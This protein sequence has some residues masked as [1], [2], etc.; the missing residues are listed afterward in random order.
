MRLLILFLL[1]TIP[2]KV[3]AECK[4]KA[5]NVLFFD[6]NS[7]VEEVDGAKETAELKCQNFQVIRSEKAAKAALQKIEKSGQ[8]ISSLIMSG[9][10]KAGMFWGK[11][12]SISS[13]GFSDLLDKYPKSKSSVKNLYL[14]GCYTNNV[15]KLDTWL[16]SFPE[17]NYVFGFTQ[18]SPLSKQI[19]GVDYLKS[20]MLHQDDLQKIE[21]LDEVK[22]F[23]D[24]TLVP[25]SSKNFHFVSAAIYGKAL[26]DPAKY[27]SFYYS[28][29][30]IEGGTHSTISGA[31]DKEAC[32]DAEAAFASKYKKLLS[33][34]WNGNIEVM[35][36]EDPVSKDRI[37]NPIRM[38]IYPWANKYAYC[39]K[40]NFFDIDGENLVGQGQLL[41]LVYFNDLKKNFFV[42]FKE[43]ADRLKGKLS[44]KNQ[45]L[46]DLLKKGKDLTRKEILALNDGLNQLTPATPEV[47]AFAFKLK[48]FLVNLDDRCADIHWLDA[49]SAIRK[50]PKFCTE[51]TS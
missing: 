13:Q 3:F 45:A 1:F 40:D 50:P 18:K 34:Y 17:L 14:W 11:N 41:N 22:E 21:S 35:P 6:F 5:G 43:D 31:K 48:K 37:K 8:E 36:L 9:H 47:K 46:V 2:F 51:P 32:P 28:V 27:N 25:G 10:H 30:Q 20:A 7:S 44:G 15:D 42:Y 19:T 16:K 39:F 12:F 29:N 4:S 38:D 24:T 33:D 49:P 23:L 26:C